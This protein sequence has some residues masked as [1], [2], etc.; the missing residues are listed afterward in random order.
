MNIELPTEKTKR[1]KVDPTSM[2]IYSHPK[3]GKT[4]AVSELRGCLTIDLQ[5]GSEFVD[6]LKFDVL[7]KTDEVNSERAAENKHPVPPILILTEFIKSLENYRAEHGEHMYRYLAIDT[8]SDLEELCLPLAAKFYRETPV[9]KNWVGK[10]VLELP[11]GA[12]YLYLRE[13]VKY[14]IKK[15]EE[16]CHCLILLGHVRDKLVEVQGEEIEERGLKMTGILGSI[17]CSEVDAVGYM[18]RE[19]GNT[20]INFK[21]SKS[22]VSE[23]RAKHLSNKVITVITSDEEGNPIVSWDEIFIEKY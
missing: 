9:G 8:L 15:L 13:A 14:I 18:Y 1:T 4:T 16:N 23:S 19:D 21:A 7:Q 20:L 6:I 3:V 17:L 5:R 12:G 11:R 2:I 10:N 22:T